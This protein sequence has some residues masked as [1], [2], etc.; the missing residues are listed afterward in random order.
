MPMTK[1]LIAIYLLTQRKKSISALQLSRELGIK[2]DA[3]WRMKHK[4]MLERQQQHPA[5]K[6]MNTLLGNVKNALLGIFHA[7]R[8]K[9]ISRYLAEFKYWFNHRFDLLAMIER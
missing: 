5:F 7:I 4:L 2:Y 9:Y 3:A 1:W 8:E 6:W